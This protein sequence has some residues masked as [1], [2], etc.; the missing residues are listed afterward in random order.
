[1]KE[2]NNKKEYNYYNDDNFLK[3]VKK[4]KKVSCGYHYFI[5][6]NINGLKI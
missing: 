6:E 1:M 5:I 4:V 3:K 2:D